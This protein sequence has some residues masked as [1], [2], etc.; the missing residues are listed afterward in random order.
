[1]FLQ[2]PGLF[3]GCQFFFSGIF[4]PKTP[5]KEELIQLVK[6]GGGRILTREPKQELD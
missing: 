3:D 6:Y 4:D 1:M 2:L 5:Q